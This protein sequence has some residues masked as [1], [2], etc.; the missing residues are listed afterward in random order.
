[1]RTYEFSSGL[2]DL[3]IGLEFLRR[4]RRGA[5]L[6]DD[7]AGRFVGEPAASGIV[8]PAAIA[9]ASVAITVS[10]APVTSATSRA[11]AGR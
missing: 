7:D 11:D 1:M 2:N 5:E 8:A 3:R 6:P 10:P 4:D 9:S